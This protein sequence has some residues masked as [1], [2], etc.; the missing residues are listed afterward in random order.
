MNTV[1]PNVNVGEIGILRLLSIALD[2]ETPH[3]FPPV[4]IMEAG[5]FDNGT[6]RSVQARGL[7]TV[8]EAI[9]KLVYKKRYPRDVGGKGNSSDKLSRRREILNHLM[10]QSI[11]EEHPQ[12]IGQWGQICEGWI[13]AGKER[14]SDLEIDPFPIIP[15]IHDGLK[16]LAQNSDF[17][18]GEVLRGL[19]E[20]IQKKAE[21]KNGQMNG[22]SMEARHLKYLGE[23]VTSLS[24][25]AIED[26][27]RL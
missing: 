22:A 8:S 4:D 14:W 9:R 15:R 24:M 2:G 26:G 19:Q 3:I 6:I 5:H 7:F 11:R 20:E 12:A 25:L 16:E 13:L 27:L 23:T 17:K 10:W 18:I 1:F 21:G